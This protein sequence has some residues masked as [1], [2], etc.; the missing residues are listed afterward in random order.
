M[1]LNRR[2]LALAVAVTLVLGA[3]VAAARP[4]HHPT[5]PGVPV[6]RLV[7]A[8]EAMPVTPPSTGTPGPSVATRPVTTEPASRSI[9]AG[10]QAAR[11][12]VSEGPPTSV[13]DGHR[14][15]PPVTVDPTTAVVA[16]EPVDATEQ[17][18]RFLVMVNTWRYD[19]PPADLTG[20]ATGTVIEQF[21]VPA[22]ERERRTSAREV[23]WATVTPTTLTRVDAR[24]VSVTLNVAQHVIT[25]TTGE[26]V[27]PSTSTVVLVDRPAGWL[28]ESVTR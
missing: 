20:L 25:N 12:S 27:R 28:V 18:S 7:L 14:S 4:H 24:R 5:T 22:G 9:L 3:V 23:A 21:G 6:T 13:F 2:L 11:P 1:M 26:T 17:A 8:R 19:T 15:A 16:H 10:A